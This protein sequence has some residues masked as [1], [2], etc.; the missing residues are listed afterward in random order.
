MGG[1]VLRIALLLL[2]LALPVSAGAQPSPRLAVLIAA[3][4]E[5][6]TSMSR[7]VT[8]ASA[9]LRRRGFAAS[10]ILVLDGALTRDAVLAFVGTVW[11]RISSWQRGDV[12][13]AV[14]AHGMFT[15]TRVSDARPGLLL[16]GRQP[17]AAH[18]VYWDEIFLALRV[19]DGVRV[20]LLPDS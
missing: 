3:P 11:Q 9:A 18:E 12:F 8:A 6:E 14:S 17:S 10:E 2:L 1:T 19:P 16:S 20:I 7:D 13:F 15:G 4:W 5:G